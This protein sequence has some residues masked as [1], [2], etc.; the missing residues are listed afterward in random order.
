MPLVNGMRIP[1]RLPSGLLL[2]VLVLGCTAGATSVVG[3]VAVVR[4]QSAAAPAVALPNH[5]D[6]LKFAVL[7]DFGNG[8][9]EQLQLAEEMTELHARFPFELVVTVGDNIYGSDSERSLRARFEVP[10]KALLDGGVKFYASL[11]NHDTPEFQ[12]HYALFN[13][14]GDLYYTFKAP[15]EDVR[16]F[17]LQSEYMNVEQIGWLERELTNSREEWKIPYFH[18]PLYSS[19]E[20]HGSELPLRSILEPMFIRHG[21]SVVFA[22]HDHIY[23]RTLPQKGIVHFVVGSGGQLRRGGLDR[24]TGI[25]ASGFDSDRAFLAV[26][27]DGD[28]MFFN[29]ISR[30]G[31]VVDSGLITRRQ[32]Q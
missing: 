11:G 28:E 27:I 23:E 9:R 31:Q 10:Y 15:R 21:V 2:L 1:R 12:R 14:G 13:M 19:G 29:A 8:S 20:R 24:G 17:A 18:H 6:S 25:T 22:G 3:P 7:G 32:T 5:Q 4:Q 26:E 30:T 16:F